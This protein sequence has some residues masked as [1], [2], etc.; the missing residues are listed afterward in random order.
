MSIE[1]IKKKL[2]NYF[3]EDTIESCCLKILNEGSDSANA[4]G[5]YTGVTIPYIKKFVLQS[6]YISN[7]KLFFVLGQLHIKKQ[8]NIIF[9]INIKKTVIEN[10]TLREKPINGIGTD[11]GIDNI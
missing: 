11:Y 10:Y 1:E 8:I 4:K 7:E 3:V 9:C 5:Y 2:I 6:E